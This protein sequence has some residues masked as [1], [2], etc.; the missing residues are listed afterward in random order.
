MQASLF[1][2][3][4]IDISKDIA[5]DSWS[6]I[7]KKIHSLKEPNNFGAWALTITNRKAIDWLRKHKVN[8]EKLHA[9]YENSKVNYDTEI[10]SNNINNSFKVN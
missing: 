7:I 1:Y 8:K 6:V 9:Y 5:Q 4:D 3:K 10:D 2:T